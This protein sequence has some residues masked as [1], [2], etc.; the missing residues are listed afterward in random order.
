VTPQ[1]NVTETTARKCLGLPCMG[2]AFIF[3]LTSSFCTFWCI[4][5]HSL[6]CIAYLVFTL[7]ILKVLSL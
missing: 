1:S 3:R 6:C 7:G 5:L 4:T 2:A